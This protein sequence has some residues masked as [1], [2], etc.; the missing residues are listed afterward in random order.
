MKKALKHGML[1][2]IRY[3]IETYVK[4]RNYL[5]QYGFVFEENKPLMILDNA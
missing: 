2:E 5:F 1:Y 4:H 3:N